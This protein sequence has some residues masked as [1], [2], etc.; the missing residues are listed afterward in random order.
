VVKVV[1]SA[2]GWVNREPSGDKSHGGG[3]E[4]GLSGPHLRAWGGDGDGGTET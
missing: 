3:G 4:G 2:D 1:R